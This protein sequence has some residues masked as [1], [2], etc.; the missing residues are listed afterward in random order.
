MGHAKP[1]R[2]HTLQDSA[3][4]IRTSG[5]ERRSPPIP[6]NEWV[7][8]I[9][10]EIHVRPSRT[11][12]APLTACL[13]AQALGVPASPVPY[14]EPGSLT[15]RARRGRKGDRGRSRLGLL[16]TSYPNPTRA[17]GSPSSPRHPRAIYPVNVNHTARAS[18]HS[19]KSARSRGLSTAGGLFPSFLSSGD[20]MACRSS[21]LSSP[22]SG[23]VSGDSEWADRAP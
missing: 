23:P 2:P 18:P 7:V 6:P 20:L 11:F 5:V 3:R 17:H 22:E 8:T 19:S 10:E 9:R 16:N 15:S 14:A 12:R 13:R 21:T 4:R 1:P